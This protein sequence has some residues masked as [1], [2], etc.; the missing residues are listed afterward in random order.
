MLEKTFYFSS[1]IISD[2]TTD[3]SKYPRDRRSRFFT[4]HIHFRDQSRWHGRTISGYTAVN[5]APL[6][7]CES[8]FVAGFRSVA[9]QEDV[10]LRVIPGTAAS[11]FHMDI[12]HMALLGIPPRY[13]WLNVHQHQPRPFLQSAF[14][15]RTP[16]L[17][18][19]GQIVTAV[20]ST[21]RRAVSWRAITALSN[22]NTKKMSPNWKKPNSSWNQ[23]KRKEGLSP[24]SL[25]IDE[26]FELNGDNQCPGE[27][28]LPFHTT[29]PQ[30]HKIYHRNV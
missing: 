21:W 4:V 7:V 14:S 27:L 6:F 29:W 13:L 9:R 2:Q 11:S 17:T 19:Q 20:W 8:F 25:P 28:P 22:N 30:R 10:V 3:H 1:K 26:Y 5:Y 12:T 16:K 23:R 24:K 18:T 15:I